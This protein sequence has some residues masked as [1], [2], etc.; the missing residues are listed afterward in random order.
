MRVN[1]SGGRLG[2]LKG[3][4]LVALPLLLVASEGAQAV[5]DRFSSSDYRGAEL[6]SGGRTATVIVALAGLAGLLVLGGLIGHVMAGCASRAV[7]ARTF[8][9]VPIV[10]FALQEHVEYWL[11][12]GLTGSP[13]TQLPFLLGLALQLPFALAAFLLARLLV[14]LAHALVRGQA[15]SPWLRLVGARPRAPRTIFVASPA[16]AG[17]SR[18]TRGPPC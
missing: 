4:W 17:G 18:V 3:L 1:A 5:L 7:P 10:V 9:A 2:G 15:S 13:A 14:R 6:L 16:F 8:A 11:A 12:H